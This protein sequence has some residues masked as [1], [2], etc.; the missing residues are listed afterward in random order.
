MRIYAHHSHRYEDRA[1]HQVLS[2]IVGNY[3][4]VPDELGLVLINQHE[5][6][7]CDVSYELEP[8]LHQCGKADEAVYDI[9]AITT[10]PNHRMMYSKMSPRK[11]HLYQETLKRSKIARLERGDLLAQGSPVPEHQAEQPRRRGRPPK[12]RS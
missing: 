1:T 10:I 12:E 6:K 3:Y 7:F 2:F 4:Q 9:E 5:S 8:K 11:R